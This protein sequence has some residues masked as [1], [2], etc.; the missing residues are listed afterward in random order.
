MGNSEAEYWNKKYMLESS[1][2]LKMEPRRLLVS[3]IDLIPRQGLAL[4]AACGV[5]INTAYLAEHGLKVIGIDISEYALHLAKE[6]SN[7]RDYSIEFVV[8]DLV[9]T[10]LPEN[11][12]DLIANF[13]YLERG[14]IPVFKQAL[15]PGGLILFDTFMASAESKET[16]QFYLAPGELEQLFS[17]FEIVHYAETKLEPSRKH[18][19]R[20][21]A[22]IVAIKPPTPDSIKNQPGNVGYQRQSR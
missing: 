12:F 19:E 18:G 14:A 20:G 22:Q 9:K 3:F 6:N 1:Q 7:D 21:A 2:W 4:D 16:K 13:H 10:W 15:K 5:G 11:H 8:A 17:G